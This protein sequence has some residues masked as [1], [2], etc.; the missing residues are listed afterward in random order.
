[1]TGHHW[2][3]TVVRIALGAVWLWAAGA[4]LRDPDGTRAAVSRH[5]AVP[6][7][8]VPAAARILP[9]V[10]ALLGVGLIVGWNWRLLAWASAALLG[11]MTASLL[12]VLLRPVPAAE[13]AGQAGC[14]CF[15]R[16]KAQDS[17]PYPGTTWAGSAIARN[18][19]LVSAAV[20]L[21]TAS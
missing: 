3:V 21:A 7:R 8:A 1:M 16:R 12:T 4:K 13:T 19:L 17:P 5:P 14:G 2:T 9:A 6:R 11:L 15:G 10:E 20:I 18:L